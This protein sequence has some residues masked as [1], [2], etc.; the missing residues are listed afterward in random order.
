MLS[1]KNLYNPTVIQNTN[2]KNIL[3]CLFLLPFFLLTGCA[4][5]DDMK[6][7]PSFFLTEN[8][9]VDDMKVLSSDHVGCS[10]N[11]IT[12]EDPGSISIT[13]SWTAICK[14]KTLICSQFLSGYDRKVSCTERVE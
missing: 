12:I 2:E 5:Y 9:T 1:T 6:D 8:I 13:N 3:K 7:L 10:P 11:E 4:T 14:G